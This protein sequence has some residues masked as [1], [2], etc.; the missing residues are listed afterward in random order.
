M[1][2]QLLQE[3][4]EQQKMKLLRQ[5]ATKSGGNISHSELSSTSV[6]GPQTQ[7]APSTFHTPDRDPVDEMVTEPNEFGLQNELNDAHHQ[8]RKVHQSLEQR[9]QRS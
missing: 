2:R 5:I 4:K 9:Q 6:L 8:L 7:N 3:M 1:E